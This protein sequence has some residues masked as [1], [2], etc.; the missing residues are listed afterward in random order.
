MGSAGYF[1]AEGTVSAP[2]DNEGGTVEAYGNLT[3]SGAV[4]GAGTFD[5]NGHTLEFDNT[6]ATGAIVSFDSEAGR[7]ALGDP[8]AF[9]ASVSGLTGGDTIDL[10]GVNYDLVPS[11]KAIMRRP[12]C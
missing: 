12:A 2:L 1:I 4:T 10:G 6:V 3:L 8:T 7:L 5:I 11:R 9:H